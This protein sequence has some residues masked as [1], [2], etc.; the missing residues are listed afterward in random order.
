MARLRKLINPELD[1]VTLIQAPQ[2]AVKEIIRSIICDKYG[3]E[4]DSSIDEMI[5]DIW[6]E[7][8]NMK[9]F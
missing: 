5:N 8:D 3:F 4:G 6:I 2:C 1:K 7:L 9:V